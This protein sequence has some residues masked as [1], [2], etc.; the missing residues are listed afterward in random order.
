MPHL[1]FHVTPLLRKTKCLDVCCWFCSA[2]YYSAGA[3]GEEI[4][5]S[6]QRTPC[7]F[8]IRKKASQGASN[9]LYR[10]NRFRAI[11]LLKIPV[12][13]AFLDS[14]SFSP[15]LPKIRGGA[16]FQDSLNDVCSSSSTI[17]LMLEDNPEFIGVLFFLI[18]STPA[19]IFVPNTLLNQLA[20]NPG[21][22]ANSVNH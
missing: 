21:R 16:G 17:A 12:M 22:L 18:S 6:H 4:K 19:W 20:L 9:L 13:V 11:Y 2:Q 7:L 14:A 5:L 8:Q 15:P 1:V 10:Q 3:V